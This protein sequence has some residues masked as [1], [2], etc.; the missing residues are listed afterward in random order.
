LNTNSSCF[1]LTGA[2]PSFPTKSYR[3]PEVIAVDSEMAENYA[4]PH[5]PY[6]T[7]CVDRF[8]SDLHL[9]GG[10]F[11]SYEHP[12]GGQL[13]TGVNHLPTTSL[14]ADVEHQF[15]KFLSGLP[16]LQNP[17]Y[18]DIQIDSQIA[19]P[20]SPR[21]ALGQS[22]SS[23]FSPF[24]ASTAATSVSK[25]DRN[26]DANPL[27]KDIFKDTSTQW[28]T[29]YPWRGN[30]VTKSSGNPTQAI[31]TFENPIELTE[32]PENAPT[33]QIASTTLDRNDLFLKSFGP[34]R[35]IL[36]PPARKGGRKGRLSRSELENLRESR[37]QG[38]C[39][40][41]RKMKD[42]VIIM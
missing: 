34:S 21:M 22:S 12:M 6:P 18:G 17:P 2:V 23:S 39:I 3:G 30:L 27:N 11:E 35:P 14:G 7:I 31:G 19:I 38:V 15:P 24:D 25:Y 41:C 9:S 40:R 33:T 36:L 10:N 13:D 37:K 4:A 42:K 16:Q 26:L 29:T 5:I 20:S 28:G 8:D 1:S 32:S